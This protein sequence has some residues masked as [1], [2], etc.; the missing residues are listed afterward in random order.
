MSHE[1]TSTVSEFGV[2]RYL[3]FGEEGFRIGANQKITILLGKNNAGKSNVLRAINLLGKLVEGIYK[4]T[5]LQLSDWHSR[6]QQLTPHALVGIDTDHFLRIE[7]GAD[8]HAKQ[9]RELL[10]PTMEIRWDVINGSPVKTPD[11]GAIPS[12]IVAAIYRRMILGGGGHDLP[13][14]RRMIENLPSMFHRLAVLSLAGYLK[15]ILNVPVFREIRD[16]KVVTTDSR[17]F[18]GGDIIHQLRDLKQPRF[19]EDHKEQ[20]FSKIQTFTSSLIGA[21][22]LTLTIPANEDK[23]LVER[24]GLRL[25]LAS[26]GTGLH[27][28]VILSTALAIHE[29]QFVTI[30]EP[31]AHLHPELQRK[32]LRFIET[33]TSNTY[34][35]TTHSNVMLDASPAAAMYHVRHHEKATVVERVAASPASRA[36]LDDLGYKASDLLQANGLVWVEGPSDRIYLNKW[37]SLAAPD[38]VEGLHYAVTFYGGKTLSHFTADEDLDEDLVQVFDI[39]RHAAVLIDRDL[40]ARLSKTKQRL[41]RELRSACWVTQG[42]EIENYLPVDLVRR[43]LQGKWGADSPIAFGPDDPVIDR[44]AEGLKKGF[45]KFENKVEFARL[46]CVH[47]SAMDVTGL[48]LQLRVS[49]VASLIRRWNQIESDVQA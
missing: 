29:N 22:D 40:Q 28:L 34:F 36:V 43:A 21:K 10:G 23:L 27:H 5:P 13:P 32:F 35:V 33:Q 39:N 41:Q 47:M 8:P 7:P 42:K 37:L 11:L 12:H 4:G 17:N 9:A 3:S 30:E 15:P 49:E 20:T 44:V 1:P 25:P 48:D 38:L 6:Q 46:V 45:S 24:N 19:G 16:E 31:E 2:A 26:Y 14:L 18:T